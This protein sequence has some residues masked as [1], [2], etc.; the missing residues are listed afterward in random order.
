V[1]IRPKHTRPDAN[2]ADI[3]HD[4][5]MCGLLCYPT[6]N[7]AGGLDWIITDPA[8]NP[9][10][11]LWVEIKT[12]ESAPYTPSEMQILGDNPHTTMVAYCAEDVLRRFGRCE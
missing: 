8:L 1:N 2:Q 11:M 9:Y 6:Y 4:L 10:V 12:D 5:R 3:V 7:L